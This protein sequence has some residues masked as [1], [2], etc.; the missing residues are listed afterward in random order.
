MRKTH[1]QRKL[2][3]TEFEEYQ[4]YLAVKGKIQKISYMHK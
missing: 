4:I 3:N 1:V 2:Q